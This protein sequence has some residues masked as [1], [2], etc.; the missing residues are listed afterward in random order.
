MNEQM[1]NS[2][3]QELKLLDRNL[4]SITGVNK[5]ISFDN[6]EFILESNMGPIHIKGQN[7]E[8]LSLDSHDGLIRIK[9]NIRGINYI[10]KISKKKEESIISKLF[11]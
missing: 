3:T 5:I 4:L 1:M 2:S 7:L 6:I 11:K 9:G 8:L 10:D